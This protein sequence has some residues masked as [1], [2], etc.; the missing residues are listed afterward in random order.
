MNIN[1]EEVRMSVI[2]EKNFI[3]EIKKEVRDGELSLR[4]KMVLGARYLTPQSRGALLENAVRLEFGL[5]KVKTHHWDAESDIYGNIEIKTSVAKFATDFYS[6]Q[7]TRHSSYL[8]HDVD[9]YLICL[10]N[11]EKDEYG[12]YMVPQSHIDRMIEERVFGSSQGEMDDTFLW[13]CRHNTDHVFFKSI[14]EYK[15]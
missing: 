6:L 11:V 1:I 5:R 10:Y 4:D 2:E 15:L 14:Q 9:H 13:G 12:C 8:H 3:D 7:Q